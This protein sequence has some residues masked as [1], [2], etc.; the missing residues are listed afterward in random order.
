MSILE[1]I[2]TTNALI[3]ITAYCNGAKVIFSAF[4]SLAI[5]STMKR[6]Y[7]KAPITEL[8]KPTITNH[9][10][11]WKELLKIKN[12]PKNPVRGG[13]PERDKNEMMITTPIM[14]FL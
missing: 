14:G 8:I 2:R 10:W 1:P 13:I 5:E 3:K 11:F 6:K 9:R 12:L 4:E 7:R